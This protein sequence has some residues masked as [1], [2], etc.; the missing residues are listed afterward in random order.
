RL[1]ENPQAWVAA[2]GSLPTAL[3]SAAPSQAEARQPVD[4]R[5]ESSTLDLGLVQGFTTALQNATGTARVN[6]RVTGTVADP[7]MN[8]GLDI[9]NGGFKVVPTGVIY[10]N[11]NSHVALQPDR[12]TVQSLTIDDNHKATLT[13]SGDLA[14]HE[15]QL[16]GVNLTMRGQDFKVVDNELGNARINSDVRVGG[17]L[18]SP[19][20]TGTLAIN[21]G[22]INIDKVLD[23]ATSSAY[24]TS[25]ETVP[26]AEGGEPASQPIGQPVNQPAREAAAPNKLPETPAEHSARTGAPSPAASSNGVF[27]AAAVD[28]HFTVPDDLVIKGNDIRVGQSSVG[29]GNVN[30][31]L[32]GDLRVEKDPGGATRLLGTVR[33]IRGTYDFQG[34][35]FDI[36]RGGIVRFEGFQPPNPSLDVTATRLISG[37]EAR[38]HVGGSVRRPQLTLSS[39]PPLDQADVLSLIVFGQPSNQLGEGQQ[40][41][42][43]QRAQTIAGGFVAG[44]LAQSIGNALNLDTFEIQTGSGTGSTGA[45]VT[46]GEQLG[47]RL[48]VKLRQGVGADNMSEFVLDYQLTNFLR[49]ESTMTQGGTAT[50]NIMQP[51]AQSG[52]DLIFLF[53]F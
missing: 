14:L 49:F 37:V 1:Q 40:V 42:L 51:V 27:D 22:T 41:S 7:H 43:A 20:I 45:T 16:G 29:M 3:L 38:V 46:V 36:Q 6:L 32:G 15:R 10:S 50:R 28:L 12:I 4:L 11:L 31:T 33:T 48:Y 8:G 5:V 47:Q 19:R 17:E 35:R 25:A 24:S 9:S 39:N 18:R 26:T 23:L 52:A 44:K 53:S 30:M 13:V 21:T 2:T 34:R